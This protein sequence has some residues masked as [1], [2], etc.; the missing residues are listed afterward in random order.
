MCEKCNCCHV[1]DYGACDKFFE[2]FNGRCVYCDHD[3]TCHPGE[4]K[5]FNGPLW[6]GMRITIENPNPNP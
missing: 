5:T 1:P 6:P 4:G 3:R 2:G